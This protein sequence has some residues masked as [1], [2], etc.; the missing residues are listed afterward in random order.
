[1]PC[2]TVSLEARGVTGPTTLP[3]H[4]APLR[5]SWVCRSLWDSGIRQDLLRT[6][7]LRT[8]SDVVRQSSSTEGFPCLQQWAILLQRHFDF[9]FPESVC[10]GFFVKNMCRTT[11]HVHL[12][13]FTSAQLRLIYIFTFSPLHIYI[14]TYISAHLH[15]FTSAHL[16]HH[17]TSTFSHL[18]ICTSTSLLIFTPSHLHISH[19]HC[20]STFSHLHICTS[21]SLLIFTSS[22]LHISHLH[23]S[24][25]FTFSLKA[26]AI[27]AQG[28]SP[29]NSL[30]EPGC[31]SKALIFG[32][33]VQQVSSF[34][35]VMAFTSKTTIAAAAG[36]VALLSGASFV[37]APATSTSHLRATASSAAAT[38][39]VQAPS[40][41]AAL[42][43]AGVAVAALTASG[44]KALSIKPQLACLCHF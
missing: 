39:S 5:T 1:M 8:S 44:R 14:F 23:L 19:L 27:L 29:F 9:V 32:Q 37:S 7:A 12:H 26:V 28:S 18:H 2:R 17:C 25:F 11:S 43:V 35:R 41:A 24:L 36:A 40:Q 15:I 21:T 4:C 34:L 33:Y 22:H 38:P 3:L 16:H 20:T 10:E 13:I 42:A 30:I 6:A 31:A